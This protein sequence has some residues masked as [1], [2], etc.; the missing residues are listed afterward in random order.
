MVNNNFWEFVIINTTC[1]SMKCTG[2]NMYIEMCTLRNFSWFLYLWSMV[3]IY[4]HHSLLPITEVLTGDGTTGVNVMHWFMQTL[5]SCMWQP[6]TLNEVQY[7]ADRDVL[8]HLITWNVYREAWTLM[9][10][11]STVTRNM[12][13]CSGCLFTYHTW[14]FTSPSLNKYP[15]K[16]LSCYQPHHYS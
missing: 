9:W 3:Y 1:G 13:G 5:H 10:L 11:K 4:F 2:V 12:S 6:C 7:P 14:D 15:F 16:W 8:I